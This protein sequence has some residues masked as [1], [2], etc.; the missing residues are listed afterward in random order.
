LEAFATC[1]LAHLRTHHVSR[2]KPL[3]TIATVPRKRRREHT[4]YLGD[5]FLPHRSLPQSDAVRGNS[6]LCCHYAPT[7]PH[8]AP[9]DSHRSTPSKSY[10]RADRTLNRGHRS[11]WSLMVFR[12]L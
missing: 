9:L 5:R 10:R 6:A 8:Y 12:L 1:N 7:P 4:L 11:T 2:C 3:L